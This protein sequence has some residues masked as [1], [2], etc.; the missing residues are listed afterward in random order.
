M[1]FIHS[2]HS[3]YS[4]HILAGHVCPSTCLISRTI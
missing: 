1:L 3:T 2:L 4:E